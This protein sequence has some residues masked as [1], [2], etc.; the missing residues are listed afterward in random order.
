M[1]PP[2][3]SR[4]ILTG[5]GWGVVCDPDPIEVEFAVERLVD[6]PPPARPADPDGRYD[7]VAL[8]GMLADS[9]ADVAGIDD[10][11]DR[12]GSGRG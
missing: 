7:R 6:L 8:A 5:L 12:T 3:D 1:L 10:Q 9:L 2:G 11:S 4:D